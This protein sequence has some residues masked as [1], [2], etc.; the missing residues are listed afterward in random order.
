MVAHMQA[1]SKHAFVCLEHL[2]DDQNTQQQ[3]SDLLKYLPVFVLPVIK[4][5]SLP[6]FTDRKVM[7]ILAKLVQILPLNFA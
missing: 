4:A 2:L 7:K 3:M 1:K 5:L 6:I